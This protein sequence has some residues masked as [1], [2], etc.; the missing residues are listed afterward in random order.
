MNQPPL[1]DV[2]EI[3][4]KCQAINFSKLLDYVVNEFCVPA[5]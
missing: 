3:R 5:I 1:A 2:E 4:R